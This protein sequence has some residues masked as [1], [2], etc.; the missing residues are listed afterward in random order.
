MDMTEGFLLSV[1]RENH[2]ESLTVGLLENMVHVTM[3]RKHEQ[4]CVKEVM[5]QWFLIVNVQEYESQQ[6]LEAVQ[7]LQTDNVD[8]R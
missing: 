1:K 2:Q 7:I 5:E 6:Q 8:T 3:E 4:L